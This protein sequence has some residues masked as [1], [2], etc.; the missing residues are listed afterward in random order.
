MPEKNYLNEHWKLFVKF[1]ATL[2]PED[3][4]QQRDDYRLLAAEDPEHFQ[5]YLDFIERRAFLRSTA[6]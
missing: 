4:E 6:A 5:P 2:P 3:L 1:I